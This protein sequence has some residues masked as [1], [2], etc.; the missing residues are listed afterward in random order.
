MLSEKRL[1]E[2]YSLHRKELFIYISRLCGSNETAEDL[3]H[4]CFESL[5][6]Y[7]VKY[8]LE[9]VNIRSFLYKTA[10]NLTINHLR[11][12]GHITRVEIDKG[13]DIPSGD[14]VSGDA[15]YRELEE[16]IRGFLMS[17]DD[18]SRSI[19]IMRKELS[20]D[21]VDIGMHLGIAERTVRRKL[22]SLLNAMLEY[23]KKNGFMAIFFI[24]MAVQSFLIVI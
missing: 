14:T 7:S 11:R 6:H 1:N 16:A 15:E 2:L 20:M 13:L 23:L 12:D 10:H 24:F 9:D 8:P 5:M 18:E 22:A 19:Y 17:R 4:D 21:A 3:L